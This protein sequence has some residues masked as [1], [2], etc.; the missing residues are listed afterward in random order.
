MLTSIIVVVVEKLRNVATFLETLEIIRVRLASC[1]KVQWSNCG[2]R[3]A[4]MVR[5]CPNLEG[6]EWKLRR[7]SIE[8][9]THIDS[10]QQN[11]NNSYHF[12]C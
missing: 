5:A 12:E 8:T 6:I 7:F 4:V 9:S 3:T 1:W 10:Q 2:L 11:T